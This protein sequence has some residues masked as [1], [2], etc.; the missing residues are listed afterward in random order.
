MRSQGYRVLTFNLDLLML[1]LSHNDALR[2]QI[3]RTLHYTDF[4]FVTMR[5]HLTVL[6][7]DEITYHMIVTISE[8]NCSKS[9]T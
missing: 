2:Q 6:K 9:W 5:L 7:A 8:R 1:N 4:S 3:N